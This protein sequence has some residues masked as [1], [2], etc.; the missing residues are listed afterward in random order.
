MDKEEQ[1]LVAAFRNM[2]DESRVMLIRQ[3]RSALAAEHGAKS[4]AYQ[5][6]GSPFEADYLPEAKPAARTNG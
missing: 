6:P 4:P 1:E 5:K 2:S 3:T